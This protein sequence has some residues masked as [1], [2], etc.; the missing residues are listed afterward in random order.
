MRVSFFERL[1]SQ[2]CRVAY[3]WEG[4]ITRPFRSTSRFRITEN[5]ESKGTPKNECV[6]FKWER[7]W[8]VMC[9]VVHFCVTKITKLGRTDA[10]SAGCR[11]RGV[12][13]RYCPLK[14]NHERNYSP[15]LC[16]LFYFPLTNGR[17]W[18]ASVIN[19]R[20]QL[21]WW[22][23]SLCF[24]MDAKRFSGISIRHFWFMKLYN[25]IGLLQCFRETK[26]LSLQ[27]WK[28]LIPNKKRE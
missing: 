25:L 6:Q 2:Q 28:F 18:T 20:Y 17:T 8:V 16:C 12:W 13:T 11:S 7:G 4:P 9:R 22:Y 24:Y 23:I 5:N 1:D 19:I 26:C 27:W 14:G 10:G 3:K 21:R 15:T